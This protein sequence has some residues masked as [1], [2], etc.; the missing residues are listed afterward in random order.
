MQPGCDTWRMECGK[1]RLTHARMD[2]N[3]FDFISRLMGF[4]L[5]TSGRGSKQRSLTL[6]NLENNACVDG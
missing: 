2:L 5:M 1:V 3:K 4:E 6:K